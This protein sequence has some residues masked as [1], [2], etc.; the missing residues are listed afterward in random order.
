[1]SINALDA[2]RRFTV[3][4]QIKSED[5]F[6]DVVIPDNWD[7]LE[8]FVD[9]YLSQRMPMMIPWNAEAIVTDDAAAVCLFRKGQ[10][11]VEF[12]LLFPYDIVPHHSH[13]RM[14]VI[15]MELGGG[16]VPDNGTGTSQTWGL[17]SKKLMPGEYHSSNDD[18]K[19]L[20]GYFIFAF[21]KWENPEEMTSA[22]IHWK[23]ETAGAKHENLIRQF[24]PGTHVV[25]GY[26]DITINSDG[27]RREL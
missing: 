19:Y 18:Q 7:T 16:G 23:G 17:T 21:Q 27:S 9:W 22:A 15:T 24:N 20:K 4:K 5:Y 10:Y 6:K 12:Y 3:W 1:M 13:P 26:A 25:D 14:E 2:E 11:Q 8:E